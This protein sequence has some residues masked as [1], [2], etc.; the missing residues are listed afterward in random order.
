MPYYQE[1]EPLKVS[2]IYLIRILQIRINILQVLDFL[3]L[4]ILFIDSSFE[5]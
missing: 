4:I 1:A 3:V 5:L 2:I